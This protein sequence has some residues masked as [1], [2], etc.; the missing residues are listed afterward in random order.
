MQVFIVQR[1]NRASIDKLS[2]GAHV[3][4]PLTF[5]ALVAYVAAVCHHIH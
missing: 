3:S 1:K 4:L 2:A 5:V